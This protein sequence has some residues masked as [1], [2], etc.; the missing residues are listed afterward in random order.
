MV[1]QFT[2]LPKAQ[3]QMMWSLGLWVVQFVQ[4]TIA[5]AAEAI[6]RDRRHDTILV[7]FRPNLHVSPEENRQA[8]TTKRETKILPVL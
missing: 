4:E 2:C 1:Q 8:S 3:Q 6:Q 5:V 7:H